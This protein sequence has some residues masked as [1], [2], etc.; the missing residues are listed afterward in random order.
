MPIQDLKGQIATPPEQPGVYLFLGRGGETLYVGKA[1]RPARPRAQLPGRLGRVAAHRRAAHR[2]RGLEVV[3]TDSVVDALVLENNLI[4]QRLP[5]YNIRLRDDKN[6]P[7]L[8][9]TTTEP[10]PRVL[11]A[12]RV[13][14]DGNLVRRPVPA[15][16][17]WPAGPSAWRTAC[18]AC[19]RATRRSRASA[20]GRASSTTSAAASRRAS[21]R[22]APRRRYG[23]GR[24]HAP[25]PRGPNAEL[26]ARLEAEMREAADGGAVRARGAPARRDPH[27]RDA[28]RPPAEDVD[29]AA[30][31]IATRSA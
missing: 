30:S 24:P 9:L 12:R 13:E 25:A 28:A 15:G 22:S 20:I 23:G 8:K 18:S 3:V 19:A 26:I 17:A 21:T 31:A 14:R 1:A 27:A 2:G 16:A 4:K 6:Y 29:H 5:R 7:F 10:F 11:V